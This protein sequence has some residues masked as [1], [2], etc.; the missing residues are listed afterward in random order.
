MNPLLGLL[1][2]TATLSPAA[3]QNCSVP[4]DT[5]LRVRLNDTLNSVDSR[6]GDPFTATVVE[7]GEYQ[8][9]RIL[10]TYHRH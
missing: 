10:R 5:A 8:N 6:V 3:T 7:A 9:A 1:I 4:Q 2:S